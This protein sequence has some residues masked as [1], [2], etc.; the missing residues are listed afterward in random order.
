MAELRR[1]C[2]LF[3]VL[4]PVLAA[5][6][7]PFVGLLTPGYDPMARTISRLAV[8]GPPAAFAVELAIVLVGVALIA[9]AIAL[10]PG[11][12]GGRALLVIAGAGLLVAAAIRLDPASASATA[13]H[14]LA[15]TIA[16]LGL[17]GAPLAF[18]SSLRRRKHWAAY[19]RVSFAFGAVEVA[20]LLVGLALLRTTFADWGAWERCFLALPMSWM[21]LLSARLL[22]AR[23]I[24]P[25]FS[26]TAEDS[27]WASNVSADDTMK[28]AA[29]SH[30]RSGS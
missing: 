18:A 25:M 12:R 20:M 1:L 26:S 22:S 21:V 19:A 3:G 9:L 14:R 27:S 5:V 30:S 10:R 23:K 2:A 8:P 15:T 17:T 11:S 13:E 6:T 29:A 28:A 7:V 24:E 16:M 4:G